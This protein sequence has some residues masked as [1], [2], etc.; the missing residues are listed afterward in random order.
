M[1]CFLFYFVGVLPV[2]VRPVL[3]SFTRVSL[4]VPSLRVYVRVLF[5]S[6]EQLS[7]LLPLFLSW[8]FAPGSGSERCLFIVLFMYCSSS[9]GTHFWF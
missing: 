9:F 3:I 8:V 4:T 6:S 2:L 5:A 1:S 7:S